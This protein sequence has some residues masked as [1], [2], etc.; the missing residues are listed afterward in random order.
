[1]SRGTV[2]RTLARLVE[3]GLVIRFNRGR[4]RGLYAIAQ[5]NELP[6]QNEASGNPLAADLG[7]D[8]VLRCIAA[9]LGFRLLGH[10]LE[11]IGKKLPWAASPSFEPLVRHDRQLSLPL[12][13][14]SLILNKQKMGAWIDVG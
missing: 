1:M 11:M 6:L 7:V 5:N 13:R 3:A 10:R 4:Q 2:Y 9:H 8:L 12:L 14:M